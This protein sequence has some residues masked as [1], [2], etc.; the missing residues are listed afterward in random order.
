MN[1]GDVLGTLLFAYQGSLISFWVFLLL[2]YFFFFLKATSMKSNIKSKLSQP[3]QMH[4]ASLLI[5]F[6]TLQIIYI[7]TH[8][9]LGV[10]P[11]QFSVV[12]DC[13]SDFIIFTTSLLLISILQWTWM[14]LCIFVYV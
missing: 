2:S 5:I 6:A 14:I 12:I 3:F 7:C 8:P 10:V 13:I 11:Y 4:V 1:I 9:S